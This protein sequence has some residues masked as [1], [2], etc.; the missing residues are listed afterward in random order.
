[1]PSEIYG[2]YAF[3]PKSY[4][5][6]QDI[7]KGAVGIGNINPP[8]FL[9]IRLIKSHTHTGVDSLKLTA[10]ATPFMVRGFTISEREERGKATWTGGA[11]ASGS[12]VL[13]YGTPFLS[14]E[15]SVFVTASDGNANI[16]VGV[17][18]VTKTGMTIY[19]RDID[20]TTHTSMIIYYI[21]KGR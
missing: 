12:V 3:A 11:A 17:G 16:V 15:V 6:E 7:G 4:V 9:E 20:A 14:D 21:V 5:R 8:L 18:S 1:M 10:E 13:T 19:W 2:A